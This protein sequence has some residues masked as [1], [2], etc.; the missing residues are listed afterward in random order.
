M[1]KRESRRLLPAIG[2]LTALAGSASGAAAQSASAPAQPCSAPE[3]RQF[4]FWLGNWAVEDSSGNRLGTNTITQRSGGCS[5][6]EE[7]ASARGGQGISIN[8]YDAAT[9]LWTQQWAG[10]DGTLLHLTGGLIEGSMV[11]EGDRPAADGV[12]R[13]RIR[14]TALRDGRVRQ[15]WSASKDGGKSWNVAFV[16]LYRKMEAGE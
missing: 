14:W 10:G 5:L 8:Y 11:L 9:E 12:V 16:G 3:F 1:R 2:F 6:L 15:E 13:D 7:W 4:D